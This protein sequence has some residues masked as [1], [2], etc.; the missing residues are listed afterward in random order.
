MT[1]NDMYSILYDFHRTENAKRPGS[2]HATYVLTGIQKAPENHPT[3]NG[4]PT[5]DGRDNDDDIMR[6]SP[7]LSSSMPQQDT[8]HEPVKTVSII[9]T[10]EEDLAGTHA[11]IIRV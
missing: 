11:H 3:T 1:I 6:S 7:Y 9:L 5:K 2:V 10:R 4:H 8:L